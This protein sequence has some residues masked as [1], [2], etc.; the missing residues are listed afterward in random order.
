[1]TTLCN[2]QKAHYFS[3]VIKQGRPFLMPKPDI[4]TI[5]SQSH[6]PPSH[7]ILNFQFTSPSKRQSNSGHFYG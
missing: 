6:L 7:N 3:G 4:H 2:T 1:L 5:L